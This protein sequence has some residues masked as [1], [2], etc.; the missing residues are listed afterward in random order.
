[1]QIAQ[2]LIE[3]GLRLGAILDGR[4]GGL[5]LGPSHSEGGIKLLIIEAMGRVVYHGEMEGGEFIFC[6]SAVHYNRLRIEELIHIPSTSLGLNVI[7][8][9][10]FP[11][12]INCFTLASQCVLL[13]SSDQA[14]IG[15][16]T[17]VRFLPELV[18]LNS[19]HKK[20]VL[21]ALNLPDVYDVQGAELAIQRR[22]H[23]RSPE[24]NKTQ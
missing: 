23:F 18:A 21:F 16:S 4:N 11:E 9:V 14:I 17:T 12:I 19:V 22:V 7:P 8:E 3:E 2:N 5:V 6:A 24:P 10:F 13:I 15:R 20:P 1:M